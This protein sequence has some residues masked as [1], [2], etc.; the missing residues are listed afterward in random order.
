MI[1]TLRGDILPNKY[2]EGSRG[3]GIWVCGG[4]GDVGVST[5]GG[6]VQGVVSI[7]MCGV[8]GDVGV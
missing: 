1:E 8:S 4:L 2:T 5:Y 3:I 7:G 6:W